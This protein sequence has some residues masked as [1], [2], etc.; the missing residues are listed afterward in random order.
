MDTMNIFWFEN[1]AG[2]SCIEIQFH[3]I[4]FVWNGNEMK[5]ATGM[6]FVVYNDDFAF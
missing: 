3:L 2:K 6:N 4:C 1:V 5:N